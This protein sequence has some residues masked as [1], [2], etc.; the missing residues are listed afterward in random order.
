MARVGHTSRQAWQLPQWERSR[1]GSGVSGTLVNSSPRKKN[2]PAPVSSSR[3]FL[4]IQPG[5]VGLARVAQ[6]GLGIVAGGKVVHAR[7]DHPDG[8][9]V[10]PLRL[11]TQR[12]VARHVTH[13]GMETPGQPAAQVRRMRPRIGQTDAH[14]IESQFPRPGFDLAA[15]CRRPARRD[16]TKRLLGAVT[17]AP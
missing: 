15:Q 11:F 5:H 9:R 14:R 7:T 8:A 1:G 17:I 3:V 2:D 10:Q 16:A 12:H 13:P 6:H 4:P